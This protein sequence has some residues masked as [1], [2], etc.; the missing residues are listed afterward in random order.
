[1]ASTIRIN[2]YQGNRVELVPAL[3]MFCGRPI[4]DGE[5][6]PVSV[7]LGGA[8]HRLALPI[9]PAD[10]IPEQP[11][12][13]DGRSD[14]VAGVNPQRYAPYRIGTFEFQNVDAKFVQE[15]DRLRN[16]PH[17]QYDP[18]LAQSNARMQM[19]LQGP[20]AISEAHQP[21]DAREAEDEAAFQ[22]EQAAGTGEVS[23]AETRAS[24]RKLIFI[25][26]IAGAVAVLLVMCIT[27]GIVGYSIFAEHRA[28]NDAAKKAEPPAPKEIAAKI[29]IID[30][31]R[32]SVTV[33]DKFS[34]RTAYRIDEATEFFD[35]E[36]RR[37]PGG[38][39]DPQLKL[40]EYCVILATP[41]RQALQ[42][43]KLTPPPSK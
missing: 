13:P 22:L 29:K 28:K 16:L 11:L 7:Q 18:Q 10:R 1:M 4:S 27:V 14:P 8:L 15:L 35:R 37:L 17:D 33:L 20:A 3:C 43:L 9:C 2:V 38:I 42:W 34:K 21:S 5:Y 19:L 36:G 26:V 30:R 39:A 6:Q 25:S 32:R 24:S 12:E 31:E 40:E 41:D 23:R